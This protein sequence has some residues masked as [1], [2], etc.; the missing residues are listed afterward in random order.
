[1]DISIIIPVYNG[2]KTIRSLINE[3]HGHLKG[4]KFSYEIIFIDDF[5]IDNSWSDIEEL[6]KI[7]PFVRELS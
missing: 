4:S 3:I 5:S 2:S 7:Y 1:M 6:C